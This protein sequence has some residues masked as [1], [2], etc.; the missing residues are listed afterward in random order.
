MLFRRQAGRP[1][2]LEA[3]DRPTTHS[4]RPTT[5]KRP[6][7]LLLT[8]TDRLTTYNDR[9]SVLPLLTTDRLAAPTYR[10]TDRP[11]LYRLTE[12]QNNKSMLDCL[13][14][15]LSGNARKLMV[16][17]LLGKKSESLDVSCRPELFRPSS[18]TVFLAL[19]FVLAFVFCRVICSW[20][21][22][23]FFRV[24]FSFASCFC[25]L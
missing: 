12:P 16:M 19:A 2:T 8:T 5:H 10:L 6:T 25:D 15:E 18:V 24:C 17:L 7:G 23:W 9:P 22:S 13:N 20:P 3:T 1:A 14:S 4:D 11:T 21:G